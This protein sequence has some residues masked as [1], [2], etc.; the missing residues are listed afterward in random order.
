MK[1]SLQWTAAQSANLS[2]QSNYEERLIGR[3]SRAPGEFESRRQQIGNLRT[4]HREEPRALTKRV[5]FIRQLGGGESLR[6][7]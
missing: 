1:T 4:D 6:R 5:G 7:G 2:M 3:D